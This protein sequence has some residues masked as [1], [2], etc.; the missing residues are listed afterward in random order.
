MT[1]WAFRL[2]ARKGKGEKV[3]AEIISLGPDHPGR[4][5]EEAEGKLVRLGR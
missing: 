4:L 3:G 1:T 2:G 5:E